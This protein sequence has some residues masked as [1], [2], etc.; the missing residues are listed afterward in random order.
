MT[1][2]PLVGAD[3]WNKVMRAAASLPASRLIALCPS[4]DAAVRRIFKRAEKKLPPQ[5]DGLF[6][7]APYYVAP[8][9]KK[10]AD[11]GAA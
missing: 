11:V 6:D 3:L 7:S 2:P 8:A 9:S 5:E 10:Q 4:C 1:R